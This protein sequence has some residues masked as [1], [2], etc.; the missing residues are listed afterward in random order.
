V[1]R[2]GYESN[3]SFCPDCEQELSRLEQAARCG[4]CAMPV[5]IPGA[6]C[7]QCM[8]NGL[9]LLEKVICLGILKD[10]LKSAIHRMKYEHRWPLAERLADRLMERS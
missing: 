4:W 10:P 7:P 8:G 6:P 3:N 1:C 9:P 5:T 2:A